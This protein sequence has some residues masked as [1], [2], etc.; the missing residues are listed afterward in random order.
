MTNVG[1]KRQIGLLG[2]TFDPPTNAHIELAERAIARLVLDEVVLIPA[3]DPW[4]KRPVV[5]ADLRLAMCMEA[6][7][8]HPK[9]SVS[10]IELRRSGPT[11]TVDTLREL[12][13]EYLDTD[14]TFLIGGDVDTSSWKD[15]AEC[16][17]LA[18][19]VRVNRLGVSHRFGPSIDLGLP[20]ISATQARFALELDGRTELVP[21][22]VA[23]FIKFM[24]LYRS[25]AVALA[26]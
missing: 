21:E 26:A 4:Q 18:R 23:R 7:E 5:T 20:D 9:L 22:G 3:A 6:I 2:G 11:Y 19:F 12:G 17:A 16:R 10:D 1:T 13:C 24:G 25:N 15:E 8:G 14:L